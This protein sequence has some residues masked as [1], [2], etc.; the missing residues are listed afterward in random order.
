MIPAHME[1]ESYM[2]R[3]VAYDRRG[4]PHWFSR[5]ISYPVYVPNTYVPLA[6]VSVQFIVY[7]VKTG[8]AVSMSE[9]NRT[10]A[11]RRIYTACIS[12]SSTDSTKI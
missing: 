9:D 7:D 4:R 3:D 12:A 1:W 10:R 11:H 2:I 6:T 5:R 8:K